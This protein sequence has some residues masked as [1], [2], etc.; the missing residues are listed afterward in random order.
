MSATVISIDQSDRVS[1]FSDI[2]TETWDGLFLFRSELQKVLLGKDKLVDSILCAIL[3]QGHVLFEDVPGI[4]KTTIIKATSRLLGLEMK[5]IQCTSDLLPSDIIGI[6][7]YNAQTNQFTFHRGPIFANVV[8]ADELNRSSPRTQSALLEAMGESLVTV[9]RET[10]ILPKPFIVFAAQNPSDHLGTYPLPESQLDRFSV[11][12]C[13][14]YPEA[15]K[16]KEIFSQCSLDPV[17]QVVEGCLPAAKLTQL[18]EVIESI[19]VSERIT[20]YVKRFVDATRSHPSLKRGLSTR[21]GISWVRMARAKALLEKR[22]YVIPDDCIGLAP[23]C[24]S[25]RVISKTGS[26]A[27]DIISALISSISI[28]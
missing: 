24:L 16:E 5:R 19:F 23:F 28:E 18:Q 17:A 8:L 10:H 15:K 25:H 11:K 27:S 12:L 14:G 1:R 26:A 2:P 4:G 6:E 7:V 22:D 13:L 9:D 21:G 3:S 20:N